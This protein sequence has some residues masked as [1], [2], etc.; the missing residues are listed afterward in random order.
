MTIP[1][2]LVRFAGANRLYQD[3]PEW[4]PRQ[5]PAGTKRHI[6]LKSKEIFEVIDYWGIVII[7]MRQ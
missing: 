6:K 1:R 7:F 5:N 4:E 2:R 3:T